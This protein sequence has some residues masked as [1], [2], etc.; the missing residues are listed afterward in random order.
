MSEPTCLAVESLI[1]DY[2]A[3]R[4]LGLCCR[5]TDADAYRRRNVQPLH[6]S[7]NSHIMNRTTRCP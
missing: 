2:M 6:P 4:M 7:F 1:L 5:L 3:E